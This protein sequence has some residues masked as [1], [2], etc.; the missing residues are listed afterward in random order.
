[1]S[2]EL[3]LAGGQAGGPHVGVLEVDPAVEAEDGDVVA[4][5]P[6]VVLRV[7]DRPGHTRYNAYDEVIM[8]TRALNVGPT[9]SS[10][11]FH[12]LGTY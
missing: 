2:P 7:Q 12:N 1:M 9:V 6:G 4:Q 11:R 10:Q 3:L 8:I 5:P